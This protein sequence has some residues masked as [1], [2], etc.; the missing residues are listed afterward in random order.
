MGSRSGRSMILLAPNARCS[1]QR[2]G[3]PAAVTGGAVVTAT[4]EKWKLLL[5]VWRSPAMWVI[6][7]VGRRRQ[8][9]PAPRGVQDPATRAHQA[10]S[11][12]NPGVHLDRRSSSGHMSLARRTMIS[13][14]RGTRLRTSSSASRIP[15]IPFK[16][17]ACAHRHLAL[18]GARSAGSRETIPE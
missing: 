11:N 3:S 6:L 9:V 15:P 5:K 16:Q 10:P 12:G 17:A 2:V 14:P 13:T 4:L 18:D 7:A 8:P 1:L